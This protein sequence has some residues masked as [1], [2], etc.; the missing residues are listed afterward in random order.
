MTEGTRSLRSVTYS[1]LLVFLEGDFPA[2]EDTASGRSPLA[3]EVPVTYLRNVAPTLQPG[4]QSPQWGRSILFSTACQNPRLSSRFI[5]FLITS[6]QL[7]TSNCSNSV[8]VLSDL[9]CGT[10]IMFYLFCIYSVQFSS[11]AQSFP[12]LCNPM[13]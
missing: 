4:F 11:V 2:W 5:F 12:T 9:F 10:L 7:F 6:S 8:N 13:V 1:A 3:S